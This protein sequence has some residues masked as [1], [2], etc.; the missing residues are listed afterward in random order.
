MREKLN[1]LIV[2]ML[3]KGIHYEDA[4]R[5]FELRFITGALAR[6]RGNLSH[7]AELLG[8]HRNTVS[9]KVAQYRIKRTPLK[10]TG[11]RHSKIPKSAAS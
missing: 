1:Q 11:R 4:Q 2:E 9:R 3:E 5:E 6:S 8:M 10:V 7:A